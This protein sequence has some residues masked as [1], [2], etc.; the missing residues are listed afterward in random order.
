MAK[1]QY[2]QGAVIIMENIFNIGGQVTGESFIGRKKELKDFRRQFVESHTSRCVYSIVGLAR[3]G[4]TS[5][6]KNIFEG[7]VPK[8]VFYHYEDIN[9]H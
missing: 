1:E 3:S 5:L 2:G 4:K 9:Y 6:V 8:E 7:Y